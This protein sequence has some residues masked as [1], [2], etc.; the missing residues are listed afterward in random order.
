MAPIVE[1][2]RAILSILAGLVN[3]HAHACMHKRVHIHRAT[4]RQTKTEERENIKSGTQVDGAIPPVGTGMK[5][6]MK[7]VTGAEAGCWGGGGAGWK[8]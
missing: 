3:T 8:T 6:K 4:D 5:V 7:E 1:C 2:D